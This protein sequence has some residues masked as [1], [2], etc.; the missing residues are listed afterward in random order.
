MTEG[1]KR[2]ETAAP[3]PR[4]EFPETFG[5]HPDLLKILVCPMA[6]AELRLEDGWLVCSRCGPRFKIE[7]GIPIMV[8]EE[9]ELPPGVSR[10]EDLPCYAEVARREEKAAAG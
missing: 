4:S 8:I 6:H 10:I 5:V 9:A 3:D 1:E 2:A 7:D